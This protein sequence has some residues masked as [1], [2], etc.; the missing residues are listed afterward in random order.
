MLP[1]PLRHA[2][3]TLFTLA[4]LGTLAACGG[5]SGTPAAPADDGL[6]ALP[7][8]AEILG[9]VYAETTQVPPDF[10]VDDTATVGTAFTL[11]HVKS[12]DLDAGAATHHELCTDDF[13]T[14]VAWSDAA[15]ARRARSG[16]MLTATE[17]DSWFEFVR[18]LEGLVDWV[19]YERVFKC[20]YLDRSGSDLRSLDGPAG[21]LNREPRTAAQLKTLSEYLWL[22]SAHNNPGHAVLASAGSAGETRLQ[23]TLTLAHVA[24]GAG[25]NGCDRVTVEDW[26]FDLDVASGEL[27]STLA[28]V[29]RFDARADGGRPSRCAD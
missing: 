2:A 4:C 5:G 22:F 7:S 11:Y 19:G 24:A 23:H 3:Q 27:T 12:Q 14:A 13:D 15:N 28:E 10:Y 16:A 18:S 21:R 1:N 9:K 8:D 29:M 6:V 20:A 26:V 17:T 25:A